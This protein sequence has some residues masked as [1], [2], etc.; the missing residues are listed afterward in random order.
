MAKITTTPLFKSEQCGTKGTGGTSISDIVDMRTVE[1]GQYSMSYDIVGTNG[2]TAG[3]TVFSY[4]G[5]AL[6]DG[7][8]I[9]TG[10]FG[11]FGGVSSGFISFSPPLMPFMKIKAVSGTSNP[12]VITA[13]LHA[14]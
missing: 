7:T 11:T 2:G 3:S 8:Y 1:V 6:F 10:T 9:N 5:C 13:E 14:R 12:A 4:L